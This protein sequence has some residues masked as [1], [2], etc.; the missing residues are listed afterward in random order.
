MYPGKY[1]LGK[2]NERIS[3]LVKRSGGLTASGFAEGAILIRPKDNTLT[4]QVIASN[5]L[6]ALKKQSKDTS[7]SID[8]IEDE[9]TK[10]SDIVG[11]NL[12][13]ILKKPGSKEDL[14][15]RN[16]DI[17][18]IP[19]LKQTVLVSGQVLYPV[20]VRFDPG[21]SFRDYISYAGGFSHKA[22]RKRAYVVYANGTAKASRSWIFFRTY[23]KVKPGSEV[24]VPMKELKK[25]I[26][27]LEIV[28]I[29]TSLTSM[30]FIVSTLIK[31]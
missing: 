22:M 24:V 31:F 23:P 12:D 29:A 21:S 6:K 27:T 11:I 5:K 26:S 16:N 2:N 14:Y 15:L 20:R 9:I 3:D 10:T 18:Q 1:V 13:K 30:L 25:P 28:T 4:E 17:L 7:N 19:Y 8:E